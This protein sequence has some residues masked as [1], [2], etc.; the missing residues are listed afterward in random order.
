MTEMPNVEAETLR[1]YLRD[2]TLALTDL[3]PA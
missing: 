1:K 3:R 2:N